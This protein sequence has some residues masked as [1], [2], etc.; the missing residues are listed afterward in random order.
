VIDVTEEKARLSKAMDKL[1]KEI[2]GLAGRLKNP[3]FVSSAPEE[4]VDEVR[5]NL[6]LREDEAAKLAAA[7]KRLADIG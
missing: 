3:A 6:A 1:A 5:A 7:M 2:G 4:V